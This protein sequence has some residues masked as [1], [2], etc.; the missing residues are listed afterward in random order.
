MPPTPDGLLLLF[1]HR[2]DPGQTNTQTHTQTYTPTQTPGP[3]SGW[4]VGPTQTQ[5]P[6]PAAPLMQDIITPRGDCKSTIVGLDNSQY[7]ATEYHH[8]EQTLH[9]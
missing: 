7:A 1:L 4:K 5:P 6:C 9:T 8:P 3:G 2:L